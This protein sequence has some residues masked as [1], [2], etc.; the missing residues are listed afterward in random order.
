MF[1]ALLQWEW[2]VDLCAASPWLR[3]VLGFS[4]LRSESAA[5]CSS[6]I[7]QLDSVLGVFSAICS[8]T[9]LVV[10][11]C[12]LF[13]VYLDLFF[14]K[15][16]TPMWQG[17]EGPA[18]QV[19]REQVLL[20]ESF[21]ILCCFH[22][23]CS[24]TKPDCRAAGQLSRTGLKYTRIPKTYLLQE[25]DAKL[26]GKTWLHSPRFHVWNKIKAWR[27]DLQWLNFFG[28]ALTLGLKTSSQGVSCSFCPSPPAQK[29]ICMCW[30]LFQGSSDDSLQEMDR[31][32]LTLKFGKEII[33][34][35]LRPLL[36]PWFCCSDSWRGL[37]C[38]HLV[39]SL[40]GR[41]QGPQSCDK[42]CDILHLSL[43][44]R[45]FSHIS[46]LGEVFCVL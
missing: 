43:E 1:E 39:P 25:G 24:F 34:L 21:I 30:D 23:L 35:L 37:L 13:C 17:K 11:S 3:G 19:V 12:A 31:I 46:V 15:D 36:I 32:A 14:L 10:C 42:S 29:F 18:E 20:S 44:S 16:F 27:R 4:W 22:S 26:R 7:L 38:G 40:K 9:V 5:L 41:P 6:L 33:S 2:P 8:Y 28:H 45:M